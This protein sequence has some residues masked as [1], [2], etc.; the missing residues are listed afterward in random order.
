MS[1]GVA[2]R[3]GRWER[4]RNAFAQRCRDRPREQKVRGTPPL[5][6]LLGLIFPSSLLDFPS[7]V[8]GTLVSQRHAQFGT[9][10]QHLHPRG[11]HTP[12][13]VVLTRGRPV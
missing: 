10:P 8:K 2:A 9:S 7:H 1:I 12:G 13:P 6:A 11:P 3:R 4:G 5:S